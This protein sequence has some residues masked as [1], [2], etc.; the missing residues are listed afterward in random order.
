M[1]YIE[2][3][4]RRPVEIRCAQP[5]NS[6]L[7]PGSSSQGV[8]PQNKTRALPAGSP[9]L[10]L[11]RLLQ[12]MVQK[13]ASDLHLSTGCR[14]TM[15]IDGD[16]VTLNRL[17]LVGGKGLY[18]ILM[19]IAPKS[20]REEFNQ[21]QDTD[22]GFELKGQARFRCNI[23]RDRRG[24]GVVFRMIPT[25]IMTIGDLDI[26]ESFVGLCERPKGLILV[27]GP[28]GSGKSTTLAA[29]IEHINQTQKKHIITVEDP[30][31]FVYANR[32]SMINQREV[33]THTQSF[34]SA[35]RAALRE[36][37]DIILVGE[38]RDLETIAIAMEMAMTGHLVLGTLHTA[39]AIG[40][41]NRIIDQFPAGQQSQ[42][43]TLLADTL[44]GVCSQ[45]L[46]KRKGGGR[47]GA[48]EVLIGTT[49][50]LNLIREGK[51]FQIATLM[52]TGKAQG[53]RLMNTA[54]K[55][56]VGRDLV[57]PGEAL[58]K[59]IDRESLKTI[60]KVEDLMDENLLRQDTGAPCR[61][62]R[63]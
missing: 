59:A 10:N 49:G 43:R 36:D 61:E 32:K 3:K 47:I 42:I 9:G 13:K 11:S 39:T 60:L 5:V 33:K 54:L 20:N 40:T 48:Y 35:L 1:N 53:M 37:P 17:P 4:T 56:L 15:R 38:M 50:V 45:N 19:R 24:V 63:I 12:I 28:T 41:V 27:T 52:Q 14:P 44:A 2:S 46:L 18:R 29:L 22:F 55:D 26:P 31:E 7:I 23:F 62:L 8:E 16:M 21:S 25:R 6:S 58:A 57:D 51:S 34:K 30:I